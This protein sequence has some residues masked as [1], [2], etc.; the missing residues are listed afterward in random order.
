[1]TSTTTQVKSTSKSSV[2]AWLLNQLEGP[3]GNPHSG[4]PLNGLNQGFDNIGNTVGNVVSGGASAVSTVAS[5][6]SDTFSVTSF[7]GKGS[8]WKGIGLCLAGAILLIFALIEFT[9]GGSTAL[10]ATTAK[11]VAR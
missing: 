6:V 10:V 8:T 11:A 1:M 9:V 4:N 2:G 5:G 7:L 3:F